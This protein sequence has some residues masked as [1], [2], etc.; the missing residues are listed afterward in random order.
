MEHVMT[1]AETPEPPEESVR[2][3]GPWFHNLHLP[4]GLETAPD[5]PLGDFP[6]FKWREIAAHIPDDLRG[7]AVLDLGCNAGFYSFE[8]ARRGAQ[9]TALDHDPHYLAQARWAAHLYGLADRIRFL[10][11]TVY[12]VAR[13]RQRFDV[14]LFMGVFYHLRHPLYALE[15]VADKLDGT[16]VFQTLTMPG[17]PGLEPPEDGRLEERDRFLDPGWPKMA[18]I[19]RKFA[20]DPT[21]WWIPNGACVEAL[22][23]SCGLTVTAR[24]GHEIWICSRG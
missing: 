17:E 15:R 11:M 21:N 5:H 14:V 9:V 23:R 24:P 6:A 8:L 18:F 22:L 1:P 13:L 4:G 12:D 19:E 7:M 20:G 2:R 16:L 3:L 10:E